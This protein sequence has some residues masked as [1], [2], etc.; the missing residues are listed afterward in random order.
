MTFETPKNH[1]EIVNDL[2][3]GKFI[4][5]N[6]VYF[7][8]L[9]KEQDFYKAFFKESFGY[10]LVLRKEF[11]YL[12][13]KST[14]E[15][16]S[17]RFTVILSILCYE[18]NLQGRDIKDRIEN[19]SFSVFEIQTLLDNSTYSDIFKLI[20]LK[21]EGIEKF[22]KELDQRNIIKLDNSKETFEFT[23]AVDLFFEFAKE[24]AE[25][26]LVSAEQ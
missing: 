4:L 23:K 2:L 18:W 21:E 14:G 20:K 6:E 24:I 10:E 5:W 26:K 8:T 3:K 19:G 22:L 13:S 1:Y 12:L 25:S 15:E 16:F 9:T 17:K 11:A 7:D